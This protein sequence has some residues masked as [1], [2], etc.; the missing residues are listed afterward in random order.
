MN[1]T[2]A[3]LCSRASAELHQMHGD[4]LRQRQHFIAMGLACASS[5]RG[6]LAPGSPLAQSELR[7]VRQN[8][9]TVEVSY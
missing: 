2:F 5:F 3:E 7:R 9:L 1:K 4:V 6:S 8:V